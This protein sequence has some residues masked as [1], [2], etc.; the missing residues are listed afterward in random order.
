MVTSLQVNSCHEP[1][2]PCS[3]LEA[4][5]YPRTEVKGWGVVPISDFIQC[6]FVRYKKVK[7]YVR[8]GVLL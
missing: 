6:T 1:S 2:E 3:V 4:G 8:V 7:N 5:H